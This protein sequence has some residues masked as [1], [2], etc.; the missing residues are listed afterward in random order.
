MRAVD[1]FTDSRNSLAYRI[2]S[3]RILCLLVFWTVIAAA[4]LWLALSRT[5]AAWAFFSHA[6]LWGVGIGIF[7][8]IHRGFGKKIAERDEAERRVR[9]GA[10]ELRQSQQKLQ[11]F[12][13]NTDAA[14]WLKNREGVYVFANRRFADV[15]GQPLEEILGSRNEDLFPEA[16]ASALRRDEEEAAQG[17][18][19]TAKR[20]DYVFPQQEGRVFRCFFFPISGPG[21]RLEGM[22]GTMVD[23]TGSRQL[24]E[25]LRRDKE[26][27]ESAGRA[28]SAFLANVSHEVRTPLHGIIGIT[29]LLLHTAMS[30]EQHSMV[31]AIR[32]AGDKLLLLL[33]DLL[34]F[35]KSEA[36]RIVLDPQ[37]F[38]LRDT[39]FEA[40]GILAPNAGKK[41]LELI[42]HIAPQVPDHLVG[43]APRLRQVL[44][45]LLSNAIKFTEA[46]EITVAVRLLTKDSGHARM[47]L[48]VTDTGIGIAPEKQEQIFSAYEQGDGSIS[49]RY[50][51]TGLGLSISCRLVELMG[52]TLSVHSKPGEGSVFWFELALPFLN[53][54][55]RP[56]EVPLSIRQLAGKSVLIVDDNAANRCIMMEQ[57]RACAMQPR[58]SPGVEDALRLLRLGAHS[59]APF[60][61]VLSDLHMPEKDG[62]ELLRLIRTDTALS[63]LPVILLLSGE[64]PGHSDMAGFQ[65]RLSKP[66]RQEDLTEAMLRVLNIGEKPDGLEPARQQAR[67]MAGLDVLLVED[68]EM[69]R[70]VASRMLYNLGHTVIMAEHGQKALDM[71]HTR[72]FDLVFMDMQMPVM[73]GVETVRRIRA[74]EAAEPNGPHLPIVAMTAHA[75]QGDKEKYL[76]LGMDAY[77][78]K[79]LLV[80]D[81]ARVIGEMAEVFHLE[82]RKQEPRPDTA[83]PGRAF[84]A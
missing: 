17:Q 40:A 74:M 48:S 16:L 52:G 76:E 77:V 7:F 22:G 28:G 71:L 43:D 14:L 2:F 20:H 50:G 32:S 44:L 23:A 49:R 51:G 54:E 75:L 68:M 18:G 80:D 1:P 26:T 4:L 56:G 9:E 29:D 31:A 78:S 3:L 70:F 27:A 42:V 58:E 15:A 39:V 10:E 11:V 13:E 64:M 59:G 38:S 8:F 12:A 63:M 84:P 69:N 30:R 41:S 60:D 19:N 72:P 55:F 73:D 61:L 24:E 6:V 65:A 34:D 45:N 5:G 62:L 36:G 83:D 57:L 46:G 21:Q 53:D 66:V 79:P 67:E 81:L 33:N 25:A 35:S 82:G 37:P 47:H